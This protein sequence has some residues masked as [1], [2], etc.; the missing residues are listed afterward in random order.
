MGR[1]GQLW[2]Y[3]PTLESGLDI[4]RSLGDE[5][6][7][8][9]VLPPSPEVFSVTCVLSIS[10]G[11]IIA[12]F[13]KVQSFPAGFHFQTAYIYLKQVGFNVGNSE[14]LIEIQF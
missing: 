13:V 9:S 2:R 14:A 1:L 3:Y 10:T 5:G 11:K 8:S 7:F 6:W 12:L 4:L